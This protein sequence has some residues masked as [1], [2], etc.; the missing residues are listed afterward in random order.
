MGLLPGTWGL[1]ENIPPWLE[2]RGK[3]LLLE[4]FTVQG[5]ILDGFDA[6]NPPFLGAIG[7]G[8]SNSRLPDV[9]GHPSDE[10][11]TYQQS[12]NPCLEG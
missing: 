7:L 4:K 11:G 2:G 10:E 8:L 9:E 3:I 12:T 6:I 5:N 1:D